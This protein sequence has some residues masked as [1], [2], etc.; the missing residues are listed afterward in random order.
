MRSRYAAYALQLTDYLLKT[1]HP[2]SRANDLRQQI[3]ASYQTTQW[4][5]LSIGRTQQGGVE[6]KVGK[7]EF[8]AHFS[9]DEQNQVLHERSRFSRYEGQWVYLD[10]EFL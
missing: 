6:D 1:T 7:V 8:V 5:G 4:L 2:K 9:A 3:E 10:G